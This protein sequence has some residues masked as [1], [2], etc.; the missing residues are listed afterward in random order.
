M[1]IW[2]LI[3]TALVILGICSPSATTGMLQQGGSKK[4]IIGMI[5]KIEANPVFQAAYAGARVAAR[6]LG[7]KYNVEVE[8]EYQSP[9][10]QSAREQAETIDRLSRSGV[11][12]IAISVSDASV[13]APA[14]D[15]AIGLGT[16]GLCFDSD[17]PL[18]KRFAYYGPN[19]LDFGRQLAKELAEELKGKG[20]IA[21]LA[22]TRTA[23]NLQ[24]RLQGMREELKQYPGITIMPNGIFNHLE[25][26]QSAVEIVKRVQ[27]EN[28]GINGW[29]FIGSWPLQMKNSLPWEPGTVKAVAGNAV[30]VELAF[31]E[32]GHVQALVG[33]NC[34]QM[35]Y[36]SVE[37]LLDKIV[38]H[39]KPVDPLL[40]TPLTPVDQSNVK[41]WT[42]NW[43][44]WL[45]KEALSK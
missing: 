4:I 14:I 7:P 36:R 21:V 12:G 8:I 18:S 39:Q 43:R 25:E 23:L 26:A 41:E 35:G 33:V 11:A 24:R 32:S 45:L 31:V 16:E 28:P 38:K 15:R 1:K 44:K 2:R 20:T 17:A 22:G 5:G 6:E 3:G 27:K 34:F 10:V 42:L 29:A 37:L 30:P 19:D 13:L 40:Y 9:R